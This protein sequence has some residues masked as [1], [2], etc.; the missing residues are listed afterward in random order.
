MQLRS[1]ALRS[2]AIIC[3]LGALDQAC[4]LTLLADDRFLG[5]PVAPF[6]PPLFSPSQWAKYER[7][8]SGDLSG[9]QKFDPELGWC[10]KPESGFGEYR[11]DW[12][13]CRI[14]ERPLAK[15]TPSGVRRVLAIGCSM[16]HGEEVAASETWCAQVDKELATIEVANLGV[17]AYGIDQALMR[18]IRDGPALKGDEVWL[19]L[20]PSAALRVT[21]LYRPLVDH[22]SLDIAF[23]PR[24]VLEKNSRLRRLQC[25]VLRIEDISHLLS[26][27]R[28]F[29]DA[30]QD[31]DFWIQ[32]VPQA[33]APR[34]SRWTHFSFGSRLL[35]TLFE[36]RGR[37]PLESFENAASETYALLAA[38]VLG[39]A[40][41]ARQ[42]ECTFRLLVLPGREDLDAWQMHG[43]APWQGWLDTLQR[44]GI[45]VLDV[46]EA[47]ILEAGKPIFAPQGHYSPEGS[48]VVANAIVKQLR[49]EDSK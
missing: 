35:L 9:T 32:R 22:W 25:P 39:C 28:A 17:A 5:R 40:E 23:K 13:G 46:S 8:V 24:F 31:E 15:D 49:S 4:R 29:L 42:Q 16:T 44:K 37:V 26:D 10:N 43:C 19:G 7:I 34:G 27:Q 45:S 2:L 38:I 14:S 48:R 6:D 18:L 41:E 30:L 47:L 1:L 21:T 20:L 12:A 36:A 3:A 33:Y 11:Y